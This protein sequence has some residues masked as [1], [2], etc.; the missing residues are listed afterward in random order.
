MAHL[1]VITDSVK[2]VVI[3][4]LAERTVEAFLENNMFSNIN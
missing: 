3:G 2:C 4:Q 1:Q